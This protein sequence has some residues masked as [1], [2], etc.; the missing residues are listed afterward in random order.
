MNY[1]V[2]VHVAECLAE[3]GGTDTLA[4]IS[5]VDRL[6]NQVAATVLYRSV[7]VSPIATEV[8]DLKSRNQELVSLS[9]A[10]S[11]IYNVYRCRRPSQSSSFLLGFRTTLR[12]SYGWR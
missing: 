10:H 5:L 6:F 3:E 12:M 9:A 1:D 8:L 4:C 7:T 2:L 11:L